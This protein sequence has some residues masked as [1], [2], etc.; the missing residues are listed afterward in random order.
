M[1]R[2]SCL[3]V[4]PI[5]LQEAV[6]LAANGLT[7]YGLLD[8]AIN[9]GAGNDT[10]TV[11]SDALTPPKVGQ[12]STGLPSSKFTVMPITLYPTHTQFGFMM[13]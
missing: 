2:L 10:V 12:F 7:A 5:P 6:Q 4:A 1:T 11:L 8:F 3:Q 9:T 13:L